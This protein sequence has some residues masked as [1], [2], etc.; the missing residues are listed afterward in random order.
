[1]ELINVS[2]DCIASLGCEKCKSK[3]TKGLDERLLKRILRFWECDENLW[4]MVQKGLYTYEYIDGWEKF[5][6]TRFPLKNAFY[7]RLNMKDISDQDHEHAEK[8][9]NTMEKKTLGWYHDTYLKNR[10]FTVGRC[11]WDLSKYVLRALQVRSGTFL[12]SIWISME[13]LIK[14]SFWILWAWSKA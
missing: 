3:K 5:E 6:E 13:G 4:L 8:I 9:W 10:S 11:I 14:D 12:H 1:M 7:S 2:G